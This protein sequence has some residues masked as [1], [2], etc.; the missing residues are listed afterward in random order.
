MLYE[1]TV[2]IMLPGNT[3]QDA[4]ARLRKLIPQREFDVLEIAPAAAQPPKVT[5]TGSIKMPLIGV[6]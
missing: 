6:K 2:K 3:P 4:E 1:A 5:G